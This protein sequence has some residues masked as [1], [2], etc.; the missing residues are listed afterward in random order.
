MLEYI[1]QKKKNKIFKII[2]WEGAA[3]IIIIINN[4]IMESQ[5]EDMKK[6]IKQA[7]MEVLEE[8]PLLGKKQPQNVNF[9]TKLCKFFNP[10]TKKGCKFGEK[11]R[12][13]H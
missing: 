9:K 13:I 1:R 3:I 6:M 10:K 5:K 4:K 11:C 7:L 12:Y 2:I 8:Q